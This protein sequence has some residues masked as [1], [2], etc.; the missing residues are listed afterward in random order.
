M[1]GT[2]ILLS[3]L[4]LL[5]IGGSGYWYVC[6]INNH[7]NPEQV[8]TD[9]NIEPEETHIR[10]DSASSVTEIV[11]EADPVITNSTAE[12]SV[13]LAV[14]YILQNPSRLIFFKYAKYD[15]ELSTED[16][17]YLQKLRLYLE[18]EPG[19]KIYVI[20]H[21]DASGTPEGLVF[22]SEQR[23]RFI[24]REMVEIGIPETQIQLQILGEGFPI[25]SNA[26]AE[27]RAKNRRVE[28]SL[29]NFKY[30]E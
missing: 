10:E 29:K 3:I 22:A 14:E 20:G 4:L 27:G 17:I 23:A 26:T 5:W 18:N 6:K 9:D 25:A 24:Q 8:V 1:R 16:H 19:K 11:L 15:A 21:S 28:I 30:N 7:C 13:V 2:L 12:D